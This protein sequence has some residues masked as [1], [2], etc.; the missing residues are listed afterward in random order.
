MTP[1]ALVEHDAKVR[2]R[3]FFAV[4]GIR[5]ALLHPVGRE[6]RDDLVSEQVEVDPMIGAAPLG[7]AEQ[8]TI[9]VTSRGEVV[10]REG[11]VEGA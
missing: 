2:H 3:H 10:D 8:L 7:A 9:E 4:D 11:E 1:I 6:M 5:H